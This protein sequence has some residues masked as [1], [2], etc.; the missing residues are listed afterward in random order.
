MPRQKSTLNLVDLT[1]ALKAMKSAGLAIAQTKVASDGSF[2]LIH[3]DGSD[4]ANTETSEAA[5][6]NWQL[7]RKQSIR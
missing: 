1:K 4:I 6:E 7:R 2:I 3:I 5:L